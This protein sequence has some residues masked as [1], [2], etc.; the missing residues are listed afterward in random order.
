MEKNTLIAVILCVIVIS[1]GYFVQAI[2]FPVE[3]PK[4]VQQEKPVPAPEAAEASDSDS[5]APVQ[6]IVNTPPDNGSYQ[7]VTVDTDVMSAVLTTKGGAVKS[8]KLKEHAEREG[9][10]LEMIYRKDSQMNA[11]ELYFGDINGAPLS[12]NFA[13]NKF[14][15]GKDTVVEFRKDVDLVVGNGTSVPVEIKKTYTFKPDEFM[16]ELA[17][18]FTSRNGKAIN[19]N[20]NGYAYSLGFGPQIGPQF[21]K[22]DNREDFRRYITL[23]GDKKK[24]SVKL[25]KSEMTK[26]VSTRN[27]WAAISGKY[28]AVIGITDATEYVTTFS[29]LP[30]QGQENAS[31]M[32]FS[33]PVVKS[34]NFIDT[35]KF[36]IGPKSS[37][38]LRRY[39]SAD[40]NGF[41][42]TKMELDRVLDSGAILGWLQAILKWLLIWFHKLIPNYGVAIILLTIVVKIV[43]YPLTK[44]S[45]ESSAKMSALSPKMKEIQD[46]YKN[47]P[48]KLNAELAALYKREGV[49]P[50][51][52]CF[53][54]LLQMPI[55]FALYGLLNSFFELRGA[56][57]LE[58]WITD[59]SQPD[60][61]WNFAPT[62]ILFIGSDIRLL[63]I[64]MAVTQI[65]SSKLMQPAGSQGGSSQQQ[66]Q[67]KMMTYAMPV[68]FLFVLYDVSS[69]LLLYWTMTNVLS[70]G[71]Q[72]YINHRQKVK[73]KAK[74]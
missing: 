64:L 62:S 41:G 15:Q 3:E 63:P 74:A 13:V 8:V 49:S 72:L 24:K 54:I 48:Q 55:F 2:F 59:L 35:F 33:R 5:S 14:T 45:F 44:K 70:I 22:L 51:S 71:Q 21:T 11:F 73:A 69:G 42:M 23:N 57:F 47:N 46:K 37:T 58:P 38:E 53:P 6:V 68:I 12:G 43:L 1:A 56:G 26:E 30:V 40:T 27:I 4:V 29:Q 9:E 16:I 25:T 50:L 39:D 66:S 17:I 28:F 60:S 61:I 67:M 10:T 36:Y 7:D 18:E 31:R 32:F 34:T 20:S 65:L 52:G 19:F